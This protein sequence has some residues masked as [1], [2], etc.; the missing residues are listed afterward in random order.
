MGGYFSRS[1]PSETKERL[2]NK[3]SKKL[4]DVEIERDKWKNAYEALYTQ[5]TNLLESIVDAEKSGDK[6]NAN[7]SAISD[8]AVAIFVDQMLA[9]PNINIRLLPD[10]IERPLYINIV[11]FNLALLQK[12]LANVSAEVI[13]HSVQLSM[14]PVE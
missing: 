11:K 2:K 8:K 1:E 7:A 12:T 9:D 5:H 6:P 14:R 13:G 10:S 4:T 3:Y